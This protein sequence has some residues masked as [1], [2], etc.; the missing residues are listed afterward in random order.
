M[1]NGIA[2]NLPNPNPTAGRPPVRSYDSGYEYSLDHYVDV[3]LLLQ[4]AD[5]EAGDV[6]VTLASAC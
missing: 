6:L 3:K 1:A 4:D 5:K 2:S